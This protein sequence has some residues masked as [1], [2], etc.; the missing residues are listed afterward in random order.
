MK[1]TS[2]E[3]DL[4]PDPKP[5]KYPHLWQSFLFWDEMVEM[6]KR[7]L[8]RIS[9]A[10]RG[11]SNYDAQFEKDTLEDMRIDPMITLSKK[12]M[13]K[14]A[15]EV[16]VWEWTTSFK[17]L[18]EG[19]LAAQL[20]AQVDDISKFSNIS[21]LWRF[22]GYAVI[23]GGREMPAKGEKLHY[24]QRLKS[25]CYLIA[26]EFVKMRTP[27]YRDLYD[28]EK[29]HLHELH[30]EPVKRDKAW[31][32]ITHDYTDAHIH[33][34]AMRKTVKIFLSHLW[35]VWRTAEGL[36]VSDPYAIAILKHAD[37]INPPN[38]TEGA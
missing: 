37:I 21:K 35:L 34:M 11:R 6:R 27:L 38:P 5:R 31:G 1:K 4:R 15:E 8:L 13:V 28:Q 12:T 9:S 20:L 22:A 17:G 3:T 24:N 26:D 25:I 19:G 23:E 18:K 32:K 16:P 2:V 36:P 33:A 14:Y 10:E 30:P 29:A 7:H